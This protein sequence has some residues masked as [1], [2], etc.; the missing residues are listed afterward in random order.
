VDALKHAV[1]AAAVNLVP[2]PAILGLGSGSTLAFFIKLLGE[3]VRTE[4]LQIVGV[5]TSYQTR[6]LARQH[7]VPIQDA[8]DIDHVDLAVDGAD[9]IDP[10]GNLIKGAGGAHVME[11]L[12]AACADRFIVV[13][14][15][16]KLVRTLGERFPIP[17]EVIVPSVPFVLR[18]LQELG[19]TPVVR[20]GPGKL[21]PVIS[22]LG[23]PI[24]DVRF[25]AIRDAAALD[26]AL[27]NL[28]GVVGHGLFV[29]MTH[30]VLVAKSPVEAPLIERRTLTRPTG[31]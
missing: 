29:N 30:D 13:A 17:V 9:E 31:R 4:Q 28:P 27:N 19:G 6:V 23:N 26:H 14:D 11:K 22:D 21:G 24:I 8:I 18:R 3:R 20:C 5:P 1:A 25:G 12:V 7:G 16:S 2:S 10:A 15:E